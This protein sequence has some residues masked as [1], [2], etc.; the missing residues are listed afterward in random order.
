MN[1]L[2]QQYLET[3]LWAD[4]NEETEGLKF[5]PEAIEKAEQDIDEFTNLVD[6]KLGGEYY[7]SIDHMNL[8][9]DFWLN[10]NYHGSGFWDKPEIYGELNSQ[11]LSN[12]CQNNFCP[13]DIYAGDDNQI[14]II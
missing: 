4:G 12:I 8:V 3:A 7:E 2:T 6:E 5:S 1:E 11:L 10:R 14:H 13:S 9:Y